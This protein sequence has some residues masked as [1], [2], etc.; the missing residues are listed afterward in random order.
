RGTTLRFHRRRE[1]TEAP[2]EVGLAP[3]ALSSPHAA[4][5]CFPC[6]SG[7]THFPSLCRIPLVPRD[8]WFSFVAWLLFNC[9]ETEGHVMFYSGPGNTGG[10]Y[11][12]RNGISARDASLP[13]DGDLSCIFSRPILI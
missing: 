1:I 12:V 5:L 4:E 3:I 2:L 7:L 8:I 11:R 6:A 10:L 13:T 9:G